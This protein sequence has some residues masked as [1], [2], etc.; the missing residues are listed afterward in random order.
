MACLGQSRRGDEQTEWSGKT[1]GGTTP[2]GEIGSLEERTVSTQAMV[3]P[4]AKFI[5]ILHHGR[6]VHV[7]TWRV[8]QKTSGS[9]PI[10]AR[11]TIRDRWLISADLS[12]NTWPP[13]WV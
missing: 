5:E 7:I 4:L 13:D 3:E 9:N 10:C 6:G 2:Q 12:G 11:W 8:R 1:S